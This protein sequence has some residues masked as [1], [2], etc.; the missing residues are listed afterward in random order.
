MCCTVTSKLSMHVTISDSEIWGSKLGSSDQRLWNEGAVDEGLAH[1]FLENSHEHVSAFQTESMPVL[2]RYVLASQRC[3]GT[4]PNV[5]FAGIHKVGSFLTL[6]IERRDLQESITHWF[7]KPAMSQEK[8]TFERRS[9]I[10]SGTARFVLGKNGVVHQSFFRFLGV[11][12]TSAR[13][14][15]FLRR[16]KNKS[17]YRAPESN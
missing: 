7:T 17:R 8:A 12:Y 4:E 5:L 6:V 1:D 13:K 9:D 15:F 14:S 11:I 2:V 10:C 16:Q 3:L